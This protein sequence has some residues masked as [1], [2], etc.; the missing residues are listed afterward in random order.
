MRRAVNW[1]S[2]P[3]AEL[4]TMTVAARGALQALRHIGVGHRGGRHG[5]RLCSGRRYAKF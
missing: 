5:Q 4:L 3:A 1:G 2:V